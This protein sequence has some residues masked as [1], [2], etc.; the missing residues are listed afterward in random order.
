MDERRFIQLVA[1]LLYR[2]DKDSLSPET[3][4]KR[5]KEW[6]FLFEVSVAMMI[7]EEYQ[8]EVT[9]E[10]FDCTKTLGELYGRVCESSLGHKK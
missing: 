8:V 4:Y 10:D 9:P 7:Q 6:N 3:R 2:T 5:L 1:G